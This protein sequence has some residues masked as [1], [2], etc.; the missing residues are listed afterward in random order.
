MSNRLPEQTQLPLKNALKKLTPEQLTEY[1]SLSVA[2]KHMIAEQVEKYGQIEF[3]PTTG[4]VIPISDMTETA[5][6]QYVKLKMK[7]DVWKEYEQGPKETRLRAINSV[8]R[9]M[10]VEFYPKSPDEPPPAHLRNGT[11]APKAR[12]FSAEL[13][14]S[15]LDSDSGSD[16]DSDIA[17]DDIVPA[18]DTL[19]AAAQVKDPKNK[20]RE[21]VE[22]QALDKYVAAFYTL[23]P[24]SYHPDGLNYELEVRFGTK[25]F[26]GPG[27]VIKP[28]TKNDYDNVIG[29][30][31]SRGFTADASAG[32]SSLRVKCE[33]LDSRTGRFKM[34]DIRVE[35]D[36]L[37]AIEKYC[38]TNDIIATYKDFPQ[39]IRFIHKRR[40]ISERDKPTSGAAI[41]EKNA[42]ILSKPQEFEEFNF[43]VTMNVEDPVKRGLQTFVTENWRKSKKEFRYINRV[44]FKHPDNPCQIDL[45]IVKTGNKIKSKYGKQII[46]PV[47]NLSE[48]GVF[49]N[50]ESYEIEIEVDNKRI[51]PA[52]GCTTPAALVADI[53]K[54]TKYVLSG[55][56]GTMYP[57]SYTEQSAVIQDYLK[58]IWGAEYD[59]SWRIGGKYFIGPNS[60]TLQLTN[61]VDGGAGGI[62]GVGAAAAGEQETAALAAKNVRKNYVV[63]EKADG[64]RHLLYVSAT[65]KLYLIS[66]NMDV[67]FTGS[68]TK[69]PDCFQTIFDGELISTD[70]R[71]NFINLYAAFDLYYHRGKDVRALPF[72]DVESGPTAAE[73]HLA[74]R[75]TLMSH[76]LRFIQPVS[77]MPPVGA[78]AGTAIAHNFSPIHVCAKQFYPMGSAITVAGDMASKMTPTSSIF[79]GCRTILHKELD[80]LYE[81]E[82]DGII[83]THTTFGVGSAHAG[84]AGSKNKITWEYSFKWKPPQFNTIDFLITTLKSPQGDDIIV[85]IFEDG[86]NP[87]AFTQFDEY[88][89]I[90]LRCGFNEKIDGYINPC[91]DVIDDKF[92]SSAAGAG[93]PEERSTQDYV[94]KRFYP[95][96]PYDINAGLCNIML[97]VDASGT[98]Q[99]YTLSDEVITDN[100]IVEFAYDLERSGAWRWIPLRVRH[101]KTAKLRRGEREY[102]NAYKVCNENWKSIHPSGRITEDML[103]TGQGIPD[104]T[105]V[106]DVYY[107]TA[108]AAGGFSR[109]KSLKHFHNL[110]VKKRLICGV[111]RP[112]NILIDFACGKAGDLPKWTAAKLAFVFGVDYSKDNLENRLDG[113]CA[114]LLDSR[115][116]NKFAPYGLFVHGNSSQN[117]RSG[118]AMLNDKAKQI[119]AAVF[120][121]SGKRP[122]SEIGKGVARQYGKGAA[123]FNVASCQFAIHY[124]FSDP[125]ALQGFL[126]NVAE[127]TAMGGYFIGTSYDGRTL[128]NE[129]KHLSTGESVQLIDD[130]KKIWE[131]Y[132]EYRENTFDD[133]SSSL[134]YKINVFQESINQYI[135]EYLVNY[136]YLER[137][138]E[139]YGF[140]LVSDAEAR[141]LHMPAGTGMF[142]GLFS[143]MMQEIQRN[144]FSA[145]N[146]GAAP[147]MSEN[148]KRISFLNRYFIYKKIREVNVDKIRLELDE[149]DH[150]VIARNRELAAVVG[151]TTSV[152]YTRINVRK[153]GKKVL[154]V[155]SPDI[156]ADAKGKVATRVI[157]PTLVPGAPE[158]IPLVIPAL[159]IPA[160]DDADNLAA[161]EPAEKDKTKKPRKTKVVKAKAVATS[162]KPSPRKSPKSPTTPPDEPAVEKKPRKTRVAKAKVAAVA[163]DVVA[164]SPKP[165]PRKSPKSPTTP[166]ANAEKSPVAAEKKPRKPRVVKA[167]VAAAATE[168]IPLVTELAPAPSPIVIPAVAPAAAVKKSRTIKIKPGIIDVNQPVGPGGITEKLGEMAAAAKTKTTRKKKAAIADE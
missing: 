133:N 39:C 35:I 151:A 27:S 156:A 166:P 20:P 165:S 135:T 31:K 150:A 159:E 72:I 26:N 79:D 41:A 90:E 37:A 4:P 160:D 5:K 48:S 137:L 136:T 106:E 141:E 92:P 38:R 96:D 153:L 45:S 99:M 110:Y 51:G 118:A 95:T 67:K 161:A 33:F 14:D 69:S 94:P 6:I 10:P 86:V 17:D 112:N 2:N 43:R 82:T 21:P 167:K 65:G 8:L 164:T 15:K 46:Q 121:E 62:A 76:L 53:R 18:D 142:S 144:K 100:T 56:Q 83:F 116:D 125:Q 55:L 64:D 162:P 115:R 19:A 168:E 145:K 152:P 7:P 105:A 122:G 109:T 57:V 44:T 52:T 32:L 16:S 126:K 74:F 101:D 80:G 66:S 34:S 93:A 24:F 25:P 117:I 149:Y 91:Q 158:P 97:R 111:S 89:T 98:K 104:L 147:D 139:V 120:G 12:D 124:F 78:A 40:F 47:Y 61:V 73:Q 9:G 54:T 154:L 103:A 29:F 49:S 84:K 123:G 157:D 22:K 131:V 42:Q 28:Y 128:F 60:V 23:A 75:Y 88:K 63:T 130:G 108:T 107:N 3:L 13:F 146:Y 113:A 1:K 140:T 155:N 132:K 114:R 77:V 138:M 143:D 148:E 163:A 59:P 68:V 102:G 50:P 134:G 127:C 11:T 71:G 36:G 70:K 129:L 119:T 30:L 81:Y 85:P 58:L 87:D